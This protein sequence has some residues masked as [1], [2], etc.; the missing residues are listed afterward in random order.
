LRGV[1]HDEGGPDQEGVEVLSGWR[2]IPP[3]PHGHGINHVSVIT[4]RHLI[5][6][7]TMGSDGTA[8]ETGNVRLAL[9]PFEMRTSSIAPGTDCPWCA[10]S[11]ED[12]R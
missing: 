3:A 2:P 11:E 10:P 9:Q 7:A 5:D 6:D 4:R 12:E 8:V 1:E